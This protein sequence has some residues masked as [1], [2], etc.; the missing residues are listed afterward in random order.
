MPAAAFYNGTVAYDLNG[1]YLFKRYN[2]HE[3]TSGIDYKYYAINEDGTLTEPKTKYYATNAEYCSSGFTTVYDNGG[4]VED[5][6]AD[7]DFRYADGVIPETEDQRTFVDANGISHFYPIWPDDYLYFGQALTYGYDASRAHQDIPSHIN[8]SGNRLQ[9]DATSNRVYR[10]PAYFQS[11]EMDMAHF[12]PNAFFAQTKNG[13]ASVV[14]YKNMTAIDFT[15]GNGDVSGGYKKGLNNKVFYAPL[16]D[17]DGLIGFRNVDLTQNLLVYTGTVSPASAATD[18]VVSGY[19]P[20]VAYSETHA[21]YRTVAIASTNGVKGH[22]IVWDGSAYTATKDHL[23]VDKQDFNCPIS[24]IFAEGNRM[25]YQRMPDLF[26]DLNKGWETVSLPFTAELVSTQDKGEITHFYSGSRTIEGSNAK[27]GHEYWLREYKGIN[28]ASSGLPDGVISATFNYPDAA[29]NDKQVDNTFLWDYYYSKNTQLD[30]NTDTYQ[31]Y[32]E[33]ARNLP[34]YPLLATAKPYIIGFPGKTYYEFDLSGDW[35]AENTAPTAPAKLDKQVISFVSE[36][37]ITIEVSDDELTASPINGYKFM[38]NYMSKKVE[39]YLMNAEGG[40]FDV[41]PEGGAMT[42]PFRPYFIAAS[43]NSAKGRKAIE[44]IVFDQEDSAFTFED[45]NNPRKEEVGGELTFFV[46]KQL[47]GV[48]S[49]L[50]KAT[51][52][53]I[54]NTSGLTIASFTIQPNETIETPLPTSGV[55]IIRAAGGKYNKKISVK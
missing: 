13:D 33:E 29:G 22:Q 38:P 40:S 42:I 36:P 39:G 2:D 18:A 7:G 3:T 26:V 28:T 16:L 24:Y 48:T 11:K 6:Y 43:T 35:T 54:F 19:L 55:Y 12:N 41:T 51:D 45:N 50:Q 49:S 8:Q 9:T 30:A 5:R 27:I 53:A 10:A 44:H 37:E 46:K 34:Q 25:W 4:Y 20:D 15:G 32:Y 14:A 17:D 47:I 1:F 31:T 23:L 52:V 21:T